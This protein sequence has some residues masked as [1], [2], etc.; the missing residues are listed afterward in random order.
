MGNTLA[1]I[2]FLGSTRDMVLKKSDCKRIEEYLKLDHEVGGCLEYNCATNK[3]EITST[4]SGEGN[5]IDLKVPKKHVLVLGDNR[6][7]SWDSRFWPGSPFLPEKEII[8]RAVWRF[9]PL[10]RIGLLRS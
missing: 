3:L 9:W 8:G 10:N 6:S 2:R 5:S 7:N 1:P 4:V